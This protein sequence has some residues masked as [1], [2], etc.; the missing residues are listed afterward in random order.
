MSNP[1]PFSDR[2]AAEADGARASAQSERFSAWFDALRSADPAFLWAGLYGADSDSETVLETA[3]DRPGG[4][5]AGIVRSSRST[6]RLKLAVLSA[7]GSP[8]RTG[9]ASPVSSQ[10]GVFIVGAVLDCKLIDATRRAALFQ[11]AVEEL[12][13]PEP[14]RR[15]EPAAEPG[16]QM[17][18]D[19]APFAAPPR[20]S[21]AAPPVQGP[22]PITDAAVLELVAQVHEPGFPGALYEMLTGNLA[23]QMAVLCR[24]RGSKI[25]VLRAS[26][27]RDALPRGSRVGH[28]RRAAIVSAARAGHAIA[29]SGVSDQGVAGI[30]ESLDL[31]LLTDFSGVDGALAF[32]MDHPKG[33][34]LVLLAERAERLEEGMVSM[35][36]AQQPVIARLSRALGVIEGQKRGPDLGWLPMALDPRRLRFWLLAGAVAL[37]VWLALPAPFNVVG[38]ATLRAGSQAT[39]VAPR[40]GLLLEAGFQAGDIV[41]AGDVLAR[42]DTRE[43]TLR[44]ARIAAQLEQAQSR[45]MSAMAQFDTAA[46]QVTDGELR[47]LGAE[48]DLLDLLLEQSELV[49][50]EDSLIV[51]GDMSDRTGSVMRQGETMFQLAPVDSFVAAVDIGHTDVTEVSEGLSGELRLTALP[52]ETFPIAIER[53]ALSTPDDAGVPGFV[54]T[55]QVG[56]HDPAFRPGM[57]GVAHIRAGEANR[58]WVLA[59]DLVLWARMQWWRWVP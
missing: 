28:A 1:A 31:A 15:R 13:R 21:R 50:A 9:M 57:Q 27:P 40:D 34:K 54:A 23:S 29:A 53:V 3:G 18:S 16:P 8:P 36:A 14:E 17:A 46:V 48:Q 5:M 56:G 2:A 30:E 4:A 24:V 39:L 58:A 41:R 59:R 38:S 51:S 25:K 22:A 11:A 19:P 10:A 52:F 26:D 47:A 42:F 12:A 44:R 20:Q 55:A 35:L 45:R 33:G 37:G 6:D 49:A 32:C 7:S 43:L